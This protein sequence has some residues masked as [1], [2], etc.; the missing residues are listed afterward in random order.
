MRHRKQ[1]PGTSRHYQTLL[2]L[3]LKKGLQAKSMGEYQKLGVRLNGYGPILLDSAVPKIFY[4]KHKVTFSWILTILLTS[5]TLI[6]VGAAIIG[7]FVKQLH[8]TKLLDVV[9]PNRH[10]HAIDL[11]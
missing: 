11:R 7:I 2:N 3:K 6:N 5:M 1:Y 10:Q 8:T 4:F 9:Y